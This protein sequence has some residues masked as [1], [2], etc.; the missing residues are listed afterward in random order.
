MKSIS[1]ATFLPEEIELLRSQGNEYCRRIWLGL[2][3]GKVPLEAK[4]EQQIRDFMIDK[5][6]RRRFYM[7][8]PLVRKNAVK[9]PQAGNAKVP[10]VKPLANL[11]NDI[12]PLRVNGV[13]QNDKMKS[14]TPKNNYFVAD[15]AHAD[16]FNAA[17]NNV[18]Q[19]QNFANFDNNPVFNNTNG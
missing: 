16:I 7:D 11:S 13:V 4:D 9:R 1:M 15:F 8:S 3:E 14:F 19:Q 5:Y 12:K 2:Y 17:N 10:D 18:N 6:E